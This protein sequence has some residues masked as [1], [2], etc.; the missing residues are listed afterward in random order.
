MSA[1]RAL[2]GERVAVAEIW[3]HAGRVAEEL[4]VPR[5]SY[6]HVRRLVLVERE[7]RAEMRKLAGRALGDVFGHRVVDVAGVAT[8]VRDAQHRRLRSPAD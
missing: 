3:R 7:Y 5:P 1:V 6:S 2:C 8:D 4:G